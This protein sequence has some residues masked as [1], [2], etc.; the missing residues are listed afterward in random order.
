LLCCVHSRDFNRACQIIG[1]KFNGLSILHI[2]SS[3]FD[4]VRSHLGNHLAREVHG[5]MRHVLFICGITIT[6]GIARTVK[7]YSLKRLV[8][9]D[10]IHP[11]HNGFLAWG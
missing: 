9:T 2:H 5:L 6:N 7:K 3:D 1:L 4:T 10:E 8:S 11:I